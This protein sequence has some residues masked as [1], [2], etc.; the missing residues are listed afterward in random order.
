MKEL[1]EAPCGTRVNIP[2]RGD[3]S[4]VGGAGLSAV[5]L[6]VNDFERLAQ[7]LGIAGSHGVHF[8]TT[9]YEQVS[10]QARMLRCHS[11]HRS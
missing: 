11:H 6:E 2:R 7:Q 1:E 3:P 4:S 8:A 9:F 5:I 10:S